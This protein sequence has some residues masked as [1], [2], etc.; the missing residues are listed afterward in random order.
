MCNG[1]PGSTGCWVR[2]QPAIFSCN[3]RKER[4]HEPP[5]G[6]LQ[7]RAGHR[8]RSLLWKSDHWARNRCARTAC[9]QSDRPGRQKIIFELSGVERI[10]SVGGV[11]LVRCYFAA[12]EAGGDLRLACPSPH[13]Q[14]LF[15]SI[16]VE[17]VI[18]LYSTVAAACEEF[19]AG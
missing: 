17:R 18:P 8:G 9:P 19:T 13:V 6:N 14:R 11:T 2:S 7:S 15:K 16:Q 3:S 5:G 1:A 12:R 4:H 10:D